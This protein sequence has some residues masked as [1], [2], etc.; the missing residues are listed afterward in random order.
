MNIENTQKAIEALTSLLES[1]K[2]A[3]DAIEKADEAIFQKN[4]WLAK[5]AHDFE[6]CRDIQGIDVDALMAEG[7]EATRERISE[8]ADDA[9][10]AEDDYH[11]EDAAG[12]DEPE[13]SISDELRAEI[14]A[15]VAKYLTEDRKDE[16]WVFVGYE[17]RDVTGDDDELRNRIMTIDGEGVLWDV[18]F[19]NDW[20]NEC[21]DDRI[22]L[23]K[24]PSGYEL[25]DGLVQPVGAD[26]DP[27]IV[28]LSGFIAAIF[29]YFPL[30]V[31]NLIPVLICDG[32][33][34]R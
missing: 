13:Q 25:R 27:S 10:D 4:D 14:D 26:E 6:K 30:S 23:V 29:P 11:V 18:A 33:P 15:A 20:N 3:L 32:R 19:S 24:P 31:R 34:K 9:D 28:R 8:L 22:I 1:Q 5:V 17:G 21:A 12:D 2:N 7:I 16:G